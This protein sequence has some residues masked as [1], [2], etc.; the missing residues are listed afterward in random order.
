MKFSLIAVI[1]ALFTAFI[2]FILSFVI[3]NYFVVRPYSVIFSICIA[4][5]VLILAFMRLSVK[6]K[7]KKLKSAQEKEKNSVITQLNL[8][9][10][11]EQLDLF[12]TALKKKDV[13]AE[14]KKNAIFIKDKNAILFIKFSYDGVTKTDVVRA[15]NTIPNNSTAY[16]FSDTFGVEL[17]NF[18]NR[19][20]GKIVAVDGY[21]TYKFLKENDCL[22]TPKYNFTNKK[23]FSDGFF[24]AFL[25]RK[26]AKSYLA[27]GFIFLV[28]SYF[29]PIKIYYIICGCSFLFLSLLCRL[30]GKEIKA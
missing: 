8:F 9:S 23:I 17:K 26:K 13:C 5:P 10:D 21:K 20:D 6:D 1:D 29:V 30:F 14:K 22:P 3:L 24:P 15:F 7:T 4:I 18:I 11:S 16:I 27:F 12:L 19:F 28:M 25:G 2:T